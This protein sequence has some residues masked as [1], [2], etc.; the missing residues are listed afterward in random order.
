VWLEILA[1]LALRPVPVSLVQQAETARPLV[2]L[3]V[4]QQEEGAE[5]P[6]AD[7]R[8]ELE[9]MAQQEEPAEGHKV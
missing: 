5:A 6:S 2:H 4:G 8:V 9:A 3:L 1:L 7:Q